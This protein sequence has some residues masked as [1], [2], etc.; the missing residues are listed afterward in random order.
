MFIKQLKSAFLVFLLLTVITGIL[1]PLVITA[2]AQIFFHHQANGSIILKDGKPSGSLLI[3]QQF[4]DPKYFWGRPSATSPTPFNGV[5]SSGSNFGPMNPALRQRTE[6]RIKLLRN[7]DPENK[8]LIPVDLVTSSASGLDPHI[9]LA[10]AQYQ[11]PRVAR[12]R[13]ISQEE[14]ARMVAQNTQS[15]LLGV[16]GEPVVNVLQLN[17]D[18]DKYK[19]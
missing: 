9:S 7:L 14:V 5:S 3:G 19:K 2:V 8:N 11:L 13:N 18:L 1:Y 10:A 16:I 15:R 12:I 4:D 6:S 17:I